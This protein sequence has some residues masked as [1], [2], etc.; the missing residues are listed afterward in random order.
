[1]IPPAFSHAY[2]ATATMKYFQYGIPSPVIYYQIYI[3]RNYHIFVPYDLCTSF[4]PQHPPDSDSIHSRRQSSPRADKKKKRQKK[5][6]TATT[7]MRRRKR[8]RRRTV[9][10]KMVSMCSE[11]PICAPSPSLRS[12]PNTVSE[13]VPVFIWFTMASLVLLRKIV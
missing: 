6:K 8:R 12:F 4:S 13:T 1:M 11:K 3:I 7:V 10:F 9:Q 2:V 5:M